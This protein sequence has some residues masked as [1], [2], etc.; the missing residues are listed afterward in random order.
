MRQFLKNHKWLK[1]I[2]ILMIVLACLLTAAVLF[3]KLWP[4]FGGR[5]SAEDRQDYARRAENYWDGKF[6]NDGDF[7]IVRKTDK[8]DEKICSAKGVMPE[9]ELPVQTPSFGK[10]VSEDEIQVTWFGHSSLLL[11]M[12]G[13]NILIDPVFSERSSPVSF[14]G[15][16]RFSRVPV[17]VEDLPEIDLLVISHDH[18]D[19][20]DYNVI[21]ELDDK[22]KQYI[23]PLG[24][25]N[26][27]ERWHISEDKIRNMAW[28]EEITVDGLTIGCTPARHYSGRSLDDQFA[29]LWASWVFQD[30]YHK[31]FESG[32]SGYGGQYQRI[33]NRYGDFDFVL[34]DCAQYDVNWPEVHMFPE[35][36][37]QAAQTLGAKTAM[38]IHWGTFALARHPWDDS[39]ERFVTAGEEAGL[40]IVTPQMG[41]TMNLKNAG[42]YKKRWWRNVQEEEA[43]QSN[44]VQ[45]ASEIRQLSDGL[46]AVRYDGD[47]GFEDFLRQ[48]GAS[49][50]SE[51]M[52]FLASHFF[53]KTSGLEFSGAVF[54][55]STL[56]VQ[57]QE[58]EHLF[59]RNFDWDQ[60]QALIVQSEP[61]EGYASLSTVNMDFIHGS[62]GM[63]LEQLPE[64]VKVLAA[65]YAPLDGM[66]EKGL[67]VAV[68]MIEDSD[69]INQT[70]EKADLT[71]TTAVRL[72]LNR[73]ADVDEA[74]VLLGKYNFHA[75]MDRMIH[76]ALSDAS[77]RSVAVEYVD[78]TMVVTD[79]PVVTNFYFAEGEKK[80]IGTKQSHTR[81]DILMDTMRQN[82]A[83]DMEGVRDALDRVSKDNFGEFESTEWSVVYN[84]DNREIHYYHREDYDTRYVFR[85]PS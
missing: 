72:L 54:G 9:G 71:T 46:S 14:V 73:A 38:P 5:A 52:K 85:L 21:R 48:G 20:L 78:D 56:S 63:E 11:Q 32:D 19:H 75:S 64:Q 47:D 1:R 17:T 61:E 37:V 13:K 83:L 62:A 55:C 59:G 42:E 29:T 77:G 84:Q 51:V 40:Q 34:T 12:H 8:K 30:K 28:W 18:Y 25:E 57:N 27:L 70:T 66:N 80:G 58:G 15:S 36:A 3:L 41:E 23:V 53:P 67:C 60:C 43:G 74:L 4:A 76:L 24:V 22:V 81:Y 50:D 6:Y 33:H 49:S 68:N 65:L 10:A 45:P 2:L 35:E 26:H 7:E 82:K 44:V 79:T 31:V 16:K 39:A 69:T